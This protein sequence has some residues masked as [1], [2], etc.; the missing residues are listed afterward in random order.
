[1]EYFYLDI[2]ELKEDC[3][4]I[5]DTNI[6]LFLDILNNYVNTNYILNKLIDLEEY[7]F[8]NIINYIN[9][10]WININNT[11]LLQHNKNIEKKNIKLT[12]NVN[13]IEFNEILLKFIDNNLAT[14]I[15]VINCLLIYL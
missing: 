14:A 15:F 11:L 6:V 7:K 10:R 3:D 1:M 12:S 4:I 8:K 13:F 9:Y 2:N 5:K